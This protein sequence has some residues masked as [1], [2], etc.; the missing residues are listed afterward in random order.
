[1]KL[2][3]IV[4]TENRDDDLTILDTWIAILRG[5]G[6]EWPLVREAFQE[7]L[8]SAFKESEALQKKACQDEYV[9][10]YFQQGRNDERVNITLTMAINGWAASQESPQAARFIELLTECFSDSQ[11]IQSLGVITN[12]PFIHA[13]QL[14]PFVRFVTAVLRSSR[15][16]TKTQPKTESTATELAALQVRDWA[17]ALW[18]CDKLR[19][20]KVFV[21][22]SN[23][24][25]SPENV[26]I[27]K[28]FAESAHLLLKCLGQILQIQTVD[29]TY[30]LHRIIIACA[31]FT[32]IKDIWNQYYPSLSKATMAQAEQNLS[33][34]IQDTFWSADSNPKGS[35]SGS[36]GG[37]GANSLHDPDRNSRNAIM[38][39][40]SFSD[41]VI[42]ILEKEIRPCFINIQAQKVA[43]RAQATIEM[44]QEKLRQQKATALVEGE[45]SSGDS[46]EDDNVVIAGSGRSIS[47]DLTRP[48]RAT[49]RF[50]IASVKDTPNDEEE[51]W[52]RMDNASQYDDP[53]L[54][55]R[56]DVNFLESVPIVE[57]CARQPIG[58]TSRILEVFMVLV[59]PILAMAE[60]VNFQ[61][62]MRGLN[63]LSRF[64]LQYH[65]TASDSVNSGPRTA[66]GSEMIWIKIFDRTGLDQVLERALTPMLAPIQAMFSSAPGTESYDDESAYTL[67]V[68]NA[69]FGAY[70]TLILVNTEPGNQPVSIDDDTNISLVQR[71][72]GASSLKVENLFIQ[73]VLGSFKRASPSKEYRTVV[74]EWLKRLESPVISLDFILKDD[75][76]DSPRKFQGIFGLGSLTIKY[77]PTLI[78]Y[79][80]DVLECPFPSSPPDVR[81]ESLILA[82]RASEALYSTMNVSRPRIPRHRGQILATLCKCWANSRIFSTTAA[83]SSSST[84]QTESSSTTTT[85]TTISS[86]LDQEQ[87]RLDNSLKRCMR[88][89]T[90]ICQPKLIDAS[91]LSGLDK[92]LK[93]LHELDPAVFGPLFAS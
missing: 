51:F 60:S 31:A 17:L 4:K 80:C 72:T 89:C 81:L 2:H 6:D 42:Q 74:L 76:L 44:H 33:M 32:N 91:T 16:M 7:A 55:K 23:L 10:R 49:T 27:G 34:I 70:L 5:L 36:L 41:H 92:D 87:A 83:S 69:A 84:D 12:T 62:R 38:I 61:Y 28:T 63:L 59:S 9:D 73:G 68:M 66:I 57:W 71:S 1:M 26:K 14:S 11:L 67:D 77:L 43:Q 24:E 8:Q 53:S 82:W 86:K 18:I 48:Q 79:L 88:F 40:G 39:P 85:T 22:R 46:K 58:D 56:W 19:I 21:S 15:P 29:N 50:K 64:L 47:K 65:D 78:P 90:E 54:P 20:P 75:S 30:S 45:S 13:I 35:S 52:A 37:E 93:I 25:G 3:N